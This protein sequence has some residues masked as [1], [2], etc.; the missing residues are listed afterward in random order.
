MDKTNNIFKK[1]TFAFAFFY[2]IFSITLAIYYSLTSTLYYTLVAFASPLFLLIPMVIEFVFKLK[3][4]YIIHFTAHVYSFILYVLGVALE[5]YH[6][7][8]YFDKFA[9]MLTGIIF[10]IMGCILFSLL[11]PRE[12]FIKKEDFPLVA[13]FSLFFTTF[14]SAMW[15]I[16][17][18]TISLILKNDPQMVISTGVSDT[19]QDIIICLVGAIIVVPS[20][21]SYCKNGKTIFFMKFY[22]S[23]NKISLNK[24]AP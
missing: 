15:E 14:I 13:S 19:M 11:K 17:E 2:F 21:Y 23:F 5:G 16:I 6:Y 10:C 1:I 12:H 22:T 20:I 7:I 18:Y 4:N 8:K 9:H 3:A 24:K